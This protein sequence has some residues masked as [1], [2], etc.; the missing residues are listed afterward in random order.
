VQLRVRQVVSGTSALAKSTRLSWSVVG[1]FD[2][3][4]DLLVGQWPVGHTNM[5]RRAPLDATAPPNRLHAVRA[6]K[7][8]SRAPLPPPPPPRRRGWSQV[9]RLKH[10]RLDEV[11]AAAG[12]SPFD[13][14]AAIADL[15]TLAPGLERRVASLRAAD[16]ARMITDPRGV[17]AAVMGVKTALPTADAAV[18]PGRQCSPRHRMPFN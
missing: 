6:A 5:S 13:A 17:A 11:A 16:L 14:D 3:P 12:L 9:K 18:G 15:V 10:E 4:S 8:S 7:A 2:I 1:T